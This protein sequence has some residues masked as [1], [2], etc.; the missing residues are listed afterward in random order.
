MRFSL[1][2][3]KTRT[4]AGIVWFPATVPTNPFEWFF[5]QLGAVSSC[6]WAE[7][8]RP[9][10]ISK[11]LSQCSSILLCILLCELQPLGPL[12]ASN[13][14]PW[15]RE[16]SRLHLGSHTLHPSLETVQAASRGSHSAHLIC[17]KSPSDHCPSFS[18]IQCSENY[19]FIEFVVFV[20]LYVSGGRAYFVLV[21]AT[22][23]AWKFFVLFCF[24]LSHI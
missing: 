4:L 22:L 19:C 23:Q 5:L 12:W 11:D 8:C 10:Q 1:W 13:S 21:T 15:F 18:D 16:S 6:T 20:K 17:F 7:D 2:H 3:V 9:L 24:F 14:A